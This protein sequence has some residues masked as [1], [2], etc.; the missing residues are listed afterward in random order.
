[1][2]EQPLSARFWPRSTVSEDG[3]AFSLT[4]FKLPALITAF[5]I[6]VKVILMMMVLY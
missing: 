4:N 2:V 6:V 1:M 3:W 5:L